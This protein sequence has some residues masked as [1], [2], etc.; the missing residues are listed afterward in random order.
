MSKHQDTWLQSHWRPFMAVVYGIIILFDFLF[1][2]IFWSLL[3]ANAAG[4]VSMQWSPL[5]L[6]GGGVFYGA[7]GAI[8]GLSAFTRGQEKIQRLK[9]HG[10]TGYGEQ[11]PGSE[12]G[13]DGYSTYQEGRDSDRE[14]L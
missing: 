11:R 13:K 14:N 3:Q 9:G 6:I 12:Y 2:P 5:T 10:D 4:V 8:I 1:A 7:M